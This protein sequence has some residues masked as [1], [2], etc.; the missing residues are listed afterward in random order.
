LA[1]AIVASD[2]TT[3]NGFSIYE[4]YTSCVCNTCPQC[5]MDFCAGGRTAS[6]GCASCLAQ[7]SCNSLEAQCRV[8]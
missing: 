3:K 7:S 4:T 8:N 2:F 6:P 5:R 1:Q